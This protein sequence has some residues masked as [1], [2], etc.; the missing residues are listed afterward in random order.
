MIQFKRDGSSV[1]VQVFTGVI[2]DGR[3]RYF[4]LSIG[5]ESDLYAQLLLEKLDQRMANLIFEI[6]REEYQRGW[7]HAKGKIRKSEFF[8]GVFKKIHDK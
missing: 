8:P 7:K 4:E 5:T 3:E 6:R 2:V 1:R